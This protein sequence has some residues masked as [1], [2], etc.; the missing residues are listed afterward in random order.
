MFEQL[1]RYTMRYQESDLHLA[2]ILLRLL[3]TILI[4]LLFSVITLLLLHQLSSTNFYSLV[5]AQQR[6]LQPKLDMFVVT[7]RGNK[8]TLN[9]VWGMFWYDRAY[10]VVIS[11]SVQTTEKLRLWLTNPNRNF[12]ET[13]KPRSALTLQTRPPMKK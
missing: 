8:I 4:F 2:F 3:L 9:S 12:N 1:A 13:S 7:D 10:M 6:F 5:Q 11:K